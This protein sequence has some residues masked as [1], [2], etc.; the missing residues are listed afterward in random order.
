[1]IR[2]DQDDLRRGHPR[3]DDDGWLHGRLATPRLQSSERMSVP[4]SVSL[5][6]LTMNGALGLTAEQ[7]G[8]G[9]G[10]FFFG[11]CFLELPS[12]LALYKVGARRWISRIMISWGLILATMSFAEGPTASTLWASCWVPPRPASFLASMDSPLG[13]ALLD[14]MRPAL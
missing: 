3:A 5:A 1:V 6:S 10:I 4:S 8:Y 7:Y 13:P 11:Y 14:Q 2:I 9:A 12:N